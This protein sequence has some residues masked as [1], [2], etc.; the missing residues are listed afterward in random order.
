MP[1]L[2]RLRNA[3][4]Q[5]GQPR[6]AATTL[7]AVWAKDKLQAREPGRGPAAMDLVGD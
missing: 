1:A 4:E 7:H 5:Q 2:K 3:D 6:R